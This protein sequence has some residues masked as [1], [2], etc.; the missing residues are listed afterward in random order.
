[1]TIFLGHDLI[2]QDKPP[3]GTPPSPSTSCG[4]REVAGIGFAATARRLG[5]FWNLLHFSLNYHLSRT[6]ADLEYSKVL[7]GHTG[8]I[9]SDNRVGAMIYNRMNEFYEIE[10]LFF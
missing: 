9:F 8:E 6:L 2:F 4:V 1:M 10:V 3:S 5:H 7:V